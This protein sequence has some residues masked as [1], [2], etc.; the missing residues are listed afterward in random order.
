MNKIPPAG[1]IGFSHGESFLARGIQFS[2]EIYIK[3]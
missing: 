2:M 1:L 3:L